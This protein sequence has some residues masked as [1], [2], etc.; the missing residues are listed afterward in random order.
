[1]LEMSKRIYKRV[2][3]RKEGYLQN[4]NI[5]FFIILKLY[6]LGGSTILVQP[7]PKDPKKSGSAILVSA[8]FTKYLINVLYN[9]F[10]YYALS[11]NL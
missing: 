5:S 4:K 3:R 1:M 9:M 7:N 8:L 6:K 2:Y 11:T 10:I